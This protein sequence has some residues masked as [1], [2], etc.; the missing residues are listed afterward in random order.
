MW[1]RLSAV[2]APNGSE[3]CCRTRLVANHRRY[4]TY[5]T[6]SADSSNSLLGRGVLLRLRA[7]TSM[8][9]RGAATRRS[10]SES[11]SSESRPPRPEGAFFS[12]S[13]TKPC[14]GSEVGHARAENSSRDAHDD[15]G[16][17]GSDPRR[18]NR[19]AVAPQERGL[20]PSPSAQRPRRI[21]QSRSPRVA[22]RFKPR[23]RGNTLS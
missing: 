19:S 7:G 4:P 8:S 20:D 14:S 2:A 9:E 13:A 21:R 17:P 18:L 11:W 10:R 1:T 6:A 22:E 3:F 16:C 5:R 23:F 12:G 15:S